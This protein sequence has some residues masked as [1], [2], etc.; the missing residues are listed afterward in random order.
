MSHVPG[1]IGPHRPF[2]SPQEFISKGWSPDV[3]MQMVGG[4]PFSPPSR[5]EIASN[6][7]TP[8][9]PGVSTATYWP[10]MGPAGKTLSTGADVLDFLTAKLSSPLTMGV[11]RAIGKAVRPLPESVTKFGHWGVQDKLPP[12]AYMGWQSDI[13]GGKKPYGLGSDYDALAQEAY[14]KSVHLQNLKNQGATFKI[15]GSP[16]APIGQGP[17]G[18]FEVGRGE[19]RGGANPQML[20]PGKGMSKHLEAI[21]SMDPIAPLNIGGK[22]VPYAPLGSDL[23]RL[24]RNQLSINPNP[25]LG[26]E[27]YTNLEHIEPSGLRTPS[28]KPYIKQGYPAFGNVGFGQA[29]DV[30]PGNPYLAALETPNVPIQYPAYAGIDPEVLARQTWQ[31]KRASEMA[32]LKA[33]EEGKAAVAARNQLLFRQ[34]SYGIDPWSA[35]GMKG[36][37]KH[38]YPGPIPSGPMPIPGIMGMGTMPLTVPARGIAGEIME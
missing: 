32:R 16:D 25:R 34:L 22:I 8:W 2:V 9:I 5:A 3:G 28:G 13:L 18:P 12:G 21:Y 31:A 38:F 27:T 11:R 26:T 23:E 29:Q 17:Y 6:P 30:L 7:L 33:V 20:I 10:D 14:D 37:D 36:L 15:S 35:M 19:L 1:H 24:L 4:M